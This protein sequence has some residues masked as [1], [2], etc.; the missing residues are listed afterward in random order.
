M[1]WPTIGVVQT[2][3]ALSPSLVRARIVDDDLRIRA[4]PFADAEQNPD[5]LWPGKL[6][7]IPETD[8]A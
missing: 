6:M 3:D 5:K 2:T 8:C 4:A 7:E 1:A